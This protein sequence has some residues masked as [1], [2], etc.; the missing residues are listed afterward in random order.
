MKQ[1]KYFFFLPASIVLILLSCNKNTTPTTDT[2]GNW[3][4]SSDYPGYARAQGVSFVINDTAY[5]GTGYNI[6]LN[7]RYQD[8]FS[9]SPNLV[10]SQVPLFP[11]VGRN[12]AV[13]FTVNNKGY[14]CS[15]YDGIN[16]LNDTYEYNPVTRTWAAKASIPNDPNTNSS[17]ARYEAVGFGI[18]S[19][20]YITTGTNN[21]TD[22]LDCWQYNPTTNTWA[23]TPGLGKKRHSAVAFTYNNKAF[24]VTGVANGTNLTDFWVFDPTKIATTPWTKLRDIANI[25]TDA[26]DDDYTDIVRSEAVAFVMDNG[27]SPAVTK[28]YLTL[29]AG[30]GYTKSTWEYDF[31]ADS[32]TRKTPYER[33]ERVGGVA[34][35]IKG[36]GFVT[37]GSN[38]TYPLYDMDEFKPADTYNA[39]D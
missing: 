9:L 2:S 23:S 7:Q 28:A 29:G 17:N 24:V 1:V 3:V 13:A 4:A 11:G 8:F 36:R 37:T 16:P 38:S 39:A 5:I 35:V 21:G 34:F 6:T 15:G 20:G 31:T 19:F 32:W 14:V 18:G 12:S 30:G 25:S 33:P 26:Y 22:F 10:W 27:A